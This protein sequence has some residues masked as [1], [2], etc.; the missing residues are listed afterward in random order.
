M[1]IYFLLRK[2]IKCNMLYDL[3]NFDP[4]FTNPFII[5]SLLMSANYLGEIFPCKVQTVFSNNMIVK[6]ILGF[7]SLMFFVVLTRPNLYTSTNFVY[8]SI[9]FYGFFMF[10]SR[11]NY[12][13]WFLVFGMFAIIYVL[14]IYLNQIESE[15]QITRNKIGDN[16]VSPEDDNKIPTQN[17]TEKIDTI[18]TIQIYLFLLS[19]PITII[20]F[21]HYLGEKKIEYG[22][23]HFNYKKF[24][25]GKPKCHNISPPYKG[26]T[27]TLLYAFK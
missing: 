12:V 3:N 23:Q 5:L 25:F 27:D 16:T 19:I 21:I 10:L 24:F 20:G 1:T 2:Y 11:L 7:L 15:N 26:F 18:K 14:Q 6:H 13:F 17:I 22:F 9:L 8:I 4:E